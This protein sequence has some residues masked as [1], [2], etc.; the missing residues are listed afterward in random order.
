MTTPAHSD[1]LCP[2]DACCTSDKNTTEPHADTLPQPPAPGTDSGWALFLDIDGT[3]LDFAQEPDDVSVSAQLQHDLHRI[4]D[5]LQ[6]AVALLSGRP[7]AQLDS[8][9]AWHMRAAAGLHG[10]E[11]RTSDARE[12]STGD[13]SVLV[14]VR[15]QAT[16]LAAGAS[17]IRLE[18]KQRALALHYRGV[19]GAQATAERI[20]A[21]LLQQAG[22]D[23]T[24]QRGNDVIELKRAGVDKGRALD[25][26]MS[27]PPFLG[28]TPWMLGDDLSDEH[29]FRAVNAGGGVSVV[30]GPRRP[31]EARF[32]LADP[33]AAR[34]WLHALEAH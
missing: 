8:L 26:L 4:H 34:A 2:E 28:R 7:L 20:A 27:Q 13:N 32:E 29:A 14:R 16:S 22:N 5:R 11:L 30:V 24:L 25:A 21:T 9:F 15:K 17:G 31:T 12:F 18:D 1:V 33:V 23:Y 3:L 10:D 6:G 19:P